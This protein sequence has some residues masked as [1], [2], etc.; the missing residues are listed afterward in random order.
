MMYLVLKIR[1]IFQKNIQVH[2]ILARFSNLQKSLNSIFGC[3]Q[4]DWKT[5]ISKTVEN[6]DIK[7]FTMSNVHQMNLIAFYYHGY[8]PLHVVS[9]QSF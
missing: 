9:S 4:F 8:V 5:N 7:E 3:N 1:I 6:S 2:P